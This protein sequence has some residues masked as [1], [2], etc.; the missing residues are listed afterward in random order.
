MAK[1][2]IVLTDQIKPTPALV[3]AGME[4]LVDV[5]NLL[6]QGYRPMVTSDGSVLSYGVRSST[7][8]NG[9]SASV[10]PGGR[11]TVAASRIPSRIRT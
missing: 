11:R 7:V 2:P 1:E 3:R 8:G 10:L 9:P 4:A 6:A 5:R